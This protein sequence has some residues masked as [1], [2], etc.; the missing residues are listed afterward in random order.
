MESLEF[1]VEPTEV[2]EKTPQG[3]RF[4]IY[5]KPSFFD[6][7]ETKDIDINNHKFFD[8][9]NKYNLMQF[10]HNP[11]GPALINLET[12]NVHYLINGFV[13]SPE[14]KNKMIHNIGFNENL[15]TILKEEK[16]E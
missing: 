5:I 10:C 1:Y 6:Q 15:T 11:T 12:G 4:K 2:T 3:K 14:E 7:E 8:L 9:L 13:L 16:D